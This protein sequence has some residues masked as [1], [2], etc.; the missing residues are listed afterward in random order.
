MSSDLPAQ[1]NALVNVVFGVMLSVWALKCAKASST[2]FS[3]YIRYIYV[4]IGLCW[5]GFYIAT[6]IGTFNN[7]NT[8]HL[9][10]MIFRPMVTV[11]LATLTVDHIWKKKMN[12]GCK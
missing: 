2:L 8:I 1:I 5:G 3:R 9:G 12:G 11:T 10:Q 6:F 7:I 4:L